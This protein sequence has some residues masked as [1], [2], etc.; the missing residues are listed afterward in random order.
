[1]TVCFGSGMMSGMQRFVDDDR[2]YLNWLDQNPDGFVINTGRTSTAAYL[3]LHRA[4]CG[5]I[6]GR[7]ARGTTFTGDYAKVCGER[8]E[9]EAFGH[10]LGGQAQ[11]CGLCLYGSH[12]WLCELG[13]RACLG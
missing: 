1:M 12:I 9:L 13:G 11:P 6:N 2:G 10:Q 8:K 5:T 7:P 3:I 4:G